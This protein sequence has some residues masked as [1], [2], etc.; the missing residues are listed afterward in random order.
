MF[1]EILGPAREN[2]K[3]EAVR[4]EELD[5]EPAAKPRKVTKSW[6][7]QPKTWNANPTMPKKAWRT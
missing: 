4:E 7:A 6:N 5:M 2:G 1:E 3:V